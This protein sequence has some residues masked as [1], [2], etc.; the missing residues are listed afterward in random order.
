MSNRAQQIAELRRQIMI[1]QIM[2]TIITSIVLGILAYLASAIGLLK[3]FDKAGEKNWKAWVPFYNTYILF[4]LCWKK[5]YFWAIP[6]GCVLVAI[7]G[8][9]RVG[10]VWAT[11]ILVIICLVLSALFVLEC[12]LAYHIARCYGK[13]WPWV[14]GLIFI[15][16]VMYIILG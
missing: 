6:I 8:N 13:S 7:I 2:P 10:S 5:D 1:Q 9:I 4:K 15:P 12:F 11:V 14:V 3:M 16:C